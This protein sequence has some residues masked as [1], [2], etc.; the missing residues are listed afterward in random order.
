MKIKMLST[1]IILTESYF[2]DK[3]RVLVLYENIAQNQQ[4]KA[5]SKNSR[6]CRL[7]YFKPNKLTHARIIS[8]KYHIVFYT[9][10]Y[11]PSPT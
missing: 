11:V 6:S 7:Q 3:K 10:C 8:Q 5:I 1:E 4:N 2:S 9:Y